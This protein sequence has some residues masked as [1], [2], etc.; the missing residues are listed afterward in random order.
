[1][2]RAIC[3][4]EL[5]DLRALAYAHYIGATIE[6]LERAIAARRKQ[7]RVKRTPRE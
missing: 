6:E 4:A 7:L 2:P 1:V 5:D 3:N